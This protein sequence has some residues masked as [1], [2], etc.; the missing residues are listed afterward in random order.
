M[1]SVKEIFKIGNGPSSS[2]TI[3]PKKAVEDFLSKNAEADNIKVTLYGSLALT[4]KGHLTDFVID[5]ALKEIPHQIVF[6]KHTATEHPNT[7]ICESFKNNIPLGNTMYISIGGGSIRIQ[8]EAPSV[9]QTIYPHQTFKEIKDYCIENDMDLFDYVL[10]YEGKEIIEYLEKVFDTMQAAIERGLKTEGKLPGVLN[11]ERKAK[12]IYSKSKSDKNKL[13]AY[14]YAVSE[15]NA[16]GGLIVC[17]P[18]CGASG[19]LPATIKYT[20]ETLRPSKDKIIEGLAV[21]GLIGNV[22]KHN[23]SISGAEAGCQAEV[24]T[25]CAM[26]AAFLAHV[27]GMSIPHVEQATEVAL[28]H[29]LGMTCDPICGYVQIPCIERNAVAAMRAVD[30]YELASLLE[31]T[32]EKITLDM[33]CQTML[34]TGKDL[35]SVYRETS[36]GGLAKYYKTEDD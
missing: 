29:H 16:C 27:N 8:G 11:I 31:P 1:E 18:T 6:D 22:V 13:C 36:Q 10:Y 33:I 3:G 7:L 28:E 21:A 35:T 26:A 32:D 4:G 23:A 5:Q 34:E 12:R 2:H 25:A 30:A 20:M 19:V 15:E 9:K 24:G 17:A 14:A